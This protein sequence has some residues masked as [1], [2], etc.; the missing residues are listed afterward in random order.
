MLEAI[1][2]AEIAFL[3][4]EVPVGAVIIYQNQIISSAFNQMKAKKNPLFHAEIEA[5]NKAM[6]YLKSSRLN[7]CDIYVSLEPCAMC[8]AAISYARI[9]RLYFAASDKKFGFCLGSNSI[10]K[11]DNAYFRPEIYS[12]I[13][14]EE[15]VELLQKFFKNKRKSD[16]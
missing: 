3:N 13:C 14:E 10:F 8:A 5:I 6:I 1:K 12:A 7:D 15:S 9:K 2:Q 16:L 4:D 11:S